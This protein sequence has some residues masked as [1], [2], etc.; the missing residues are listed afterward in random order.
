MKPAIEV[1]GPENCAGCF[2]CYNSCSY[3]VIEMVENEEGFYYP[4]INDNCTACGV[5]QKFCPVINPIRFVDEF[6][7]KF[8]AGWSKDDDTRI[9]SSS[10][11][12]FPELARYILENEGVVF[13]VAWNE[14]LLPV[15]VKITD[16]DEIPRLMGSKYV[17]SNVGKTYKE[18]LSELRKGKIILFSGTPCQIAGLNTF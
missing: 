7:P 15:H 3:N 18:A 9:N 6:S 14:N 8:Y 5:C 2:A 10:G 13:G 4:D 17:Q 1:I 11:G 16:V 12:M